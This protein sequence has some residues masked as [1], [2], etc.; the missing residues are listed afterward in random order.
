M[1]QVSRTFDKICLREIYNVGQARSQVFY[2]EMR[3]NEETD[4]R[5]PEGQVSRGGALDVWDWIA[6][7]VCKGGV[8]GSLRAH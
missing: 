4:Q 3:S 1:N 5:K 7:Q 6:Q 8:G 2:G